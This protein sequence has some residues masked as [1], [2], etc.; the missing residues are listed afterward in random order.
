MV[1]GSLEDLDTLRAAA[2]EADGVIHLAFNH[3]VAFAQGDF[4][5]AAEADRAAVEAM[6]EP[7]AGTGK[8]FVLA[9]GT[10]VAAG[11]VATERDG[12]DLP[13]LDAVPPEAAGMVVRMATAERLRRDWCAAA[14]RRRTGRRGRRGRVRTPRGAGVG[15]AGLDAARRRR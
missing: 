11:R 12:H 2:A 6:A 5:A 10:P 14:V 13:P 15:S 4:M 9:S 3:E 1:R 7:L 8:P